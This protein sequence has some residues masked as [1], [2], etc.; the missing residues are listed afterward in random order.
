MKA[1]PSG[2]ILNLR[3]SAQQKCGAV[4]RRARVDGPQIVVSLNSRLESDEEEEECGV[5][6]GHLVVTAGGSNLARFQTV[7][8]N[9]SDLVLEEFA[10]GV[11]PAQGS[12]FRVQG[13]EFRVQGSGFRAE[14]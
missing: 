11:G 6:K 4:P 2:I 5:Q 8:E 12:G 7:P 14:G 3:T 13:S 1:V 9:D 10:S